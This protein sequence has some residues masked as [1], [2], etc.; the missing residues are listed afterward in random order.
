[1]SNKSIQNITAR[2]GLQEDDV[3]N[4]KMASDTL[5]KIM[6]LNL[7][8]NPIHFTLVY[9]TLSQIDS[10]ISKKIENEIASENYPESADYLFIEFI[11]KILYQHLPTDKVQALLVD[12][13]EEIENWLES[14]KSNQAIVTQELQEFTKLELPTEIKNRLKERVLPKLNSIFD[15][16]SRLKSQVS[17]SAHEITQLKN[18]LE[19]I[20]KVANTDELTGIAN[21]R[22]FN[23]IIEQ[24]AHT[25]DTDETGD[26]DFTLL[27]IDIDF[28]KNINDE[29]G[30]LIGDSVLRY[31][32]KQL[33][34]ETKGKDFIARIGGE[35]FVILLP[36][37]HHDNALRVAENLR[38]KVEKNLLKVKNYHKPLSLT[39]SIGV[40]TYQ[41]TDSIDKLFDRADKA[42]YAAKNN[43]RNKVC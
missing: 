32:A 3:L 34:A 11:S 17:H 22:G 37:T 2:Y 41:Q 6:G 23:E 18:E 21:R 20:Q 13:L 28:F 16:T 39:I 40:S 33:L 35:E 10:D 27:L 9:E 15:D 29:Y 12:L 42:L 8:P 36:Q 5:D 14:S 26:S 24:L 7:S 1:M 4:S 25:A 31:L 38:E 19:Q 43:G 30:H